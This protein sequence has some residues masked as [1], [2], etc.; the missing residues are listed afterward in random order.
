MRTRQWLLTTV[1]CGGLVFAGGMA[2]QAEAMS[3]KLLQPNSNWAISKLAAAQTGGKPYCAL[4]RRFSNNMILTMARNGQDETSVA[5]DFQKQT[6]NNT[7]NYFITLKPGFGQERSFNVRPVSGK[8]LVIRMGQD[9]AFHDALNR[10]GQ[11][12][13]DIAGDSYSFGLEDY[14]DGQHKLGQCLAGLVEPAAGPS[15]MTPI[16][17]APAYTKVSSEPIPVQA[18]PAVAQAPTPA[19][20]AAPIPVPAPVQVVDNSAELQTLREE[21]MRLRNALERERRNYEDRFM[22]EGQTSSLVAELSEKVNLLQM[23]N[24]TLQEQVAYT[25]APQPL[26][27]PEPV[28][29]DMS[30]AEALEQQVKSLRD[31]N[32]AMKQEIAG[33]QAKMQMQQAQLAEKAAAPAVDPAEAAVVDSLRE[34]VGALE[35]E[36]RQL[37]ATNA[38]Y[39]QG[40]GDV[41]VSLAQLRV[42]EEQLRHVQH[43]RDQL[44]SQIN[45]M[46]S[47]KQQ[48][49]IDISSDNWNLEQ[50][51]R[52]FNEAEMEIRRL[53]RELEEQRMHCSMEKKELEYML[54]DPSVATQEQISRLTRLEEQVNQAQAILDEQV[55]V[56][57]QK[58]ASMESK[59]DGNQEALAVQKAEYEQKLAV[60]KQELE[61][62]DQEMSQVAQQKIALLEQQ[63][64]GRDAEIVATRQ[65]I[66]QLEERLTGK[67][68][69]VAQ[70]DAAQQQIAVLEQQVAARTKEAADARQQIASLEDQL[71]KRSEEVAGTYQKIAMLEQKLAGD[72][73]A[74]SDAAQQKIA[75]LESE[76]Q[77]VKSEAAT[78]VSSAAFD[79]LRQERDQLASQKQSIETELQQARSDAA[80]KVSSSAFD[81]LRQERDLLASQKQSIESENVKL[82]AQI[83]S[84]EQ[85]LSSVN[86]AVA[87]QA[88]EKESAAEQDYA[89]LVRENNELT[90]QK[91]ALQQE[92]NRLADE[93]HKLNKQIL[94]LEASMANDIQTA[95]G[96][97]IDDP[98][99]PVPKTAA[100]SMASMPAPVAAEPIDMH[101]A[102]GDKVAVANTVSK[103]GVSGGAYQDFGKSVDQTVKSIEPAGK[104][105]TASALQ[106]VLSGANVAPHGNVQ[107]ESEQGRD[108]VAF[109]WD[110]G[111]MFGSAEQQ[112]MAKA[113]MF[114]ELSSMYLEKTKSRCQGDFAAVPAVSKE[115]GSMRISSYEIACVSGQNGA[116]ASV[117]FYS[118]GNLFTTIAHETGLDAMDAAMDARD[119]LVHYLL[120]T[121]LASR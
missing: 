47:G 93:T 31:E 118:D 90:V 35:N 33:L 87:A 73:Q 106:T 72:G 70:S 11:L 119:N 75:T 16:P 28:M 117:I 95:A 107:L 86:V 9:Y 8:A 52:R 71:A 50:A 113:G 38:S 58:L 24:K 37:K 92:K 41:P 116:T 67:N 27:C 97:I 114:D 40:G 17:P 49:R 74:A 115:S 39:A 77:Q 42:V 19:P 21:N 55:S 10:S 109:S 89:A 61:G 62:R 96:P 1:M 36:N 78:K 59:A 60:L 46:N 120:Q 98:V 76:L 81:T 6:L 7:Q 100:V 2:K 54:F 88:S 22:Q 101:D 34:R 48:D 121:Q 94:A 103:A 20:V 57:E 63:V 105:I 4:A 84:L 111:P 65:Q 108:F 14:A 45:A 30:A 26:S 91:E 43:D 85:Q 102:Y 83:A 112:I 25:P 32:L 64:A 51:T 66:A 99:P 82:G 3:G 68:V 44:L 12:D 18:T 69:A 79:T 80:A 29:P 56:Y 5:I 110:A 13:I 104:L 23:E 15:D 53:S